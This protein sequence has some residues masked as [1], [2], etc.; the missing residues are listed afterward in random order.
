MSQDRRRPAHPQPIIEPD[1]RLML[2]L[3]THSEIKPASKAD[4]ARM[5]AEVAERFRHGGFDCEVLVDTPP[6]GTPRRL[7]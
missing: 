3:S 7:H 2:R 4:S 5:A 1:E 6:D